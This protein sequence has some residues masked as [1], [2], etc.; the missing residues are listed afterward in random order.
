MDGS[1]AGN[2]LQ[3][4][5]RSRAALDL[6]HRLLSRD[7]PVDLGLDSVVG[8]LL[9][10]FVARSAGIADFQNGQS[11][12]VRCSNND[13]A[14]P[15]LFPWEIDAD[16]LSRIRQSP[17]AEVIVSGNDT[18]LVAG[19][20]SVMGG[21]WLIWI[22]AT[23]QS[24]CEKGDTLSEARG[25]SPLVRTGS[26]TGW[27]AAEKG[28]LVLVAQSIAHR[29]SDPGT[30]GRWVK[31]LEQR[32][33]QQ[34]LE[35]A[36]A[37]TRRL[38]HDFGNVLTG[39]L[40]F[41]ELALAHPQPVSGPLYRFLDEIYRSAQ[42]GANL[43][44]QLQ[45]FSRRQAVSHRNG[46]LATVLAEEETRFRSEAEGSIR[47]ESS[48][49]ADLPL[50]AFDLDPLREVLRA[51]FDNARDAV[52]EQG[53]VTVSAQCVLLSESDSLEHYGYLR[54]GPHVEVCV[55]DSGPGLSQEAKR[56][57][58]VEPFFT[59]KARRR[60]L[61]LAVA[62]GLLSAY[63]GGMSLSSKPGEG[64]VVKVLLPVAA[65]PALPV[66]VA[67]IVRLKPAADR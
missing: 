41:S 11:V 25:D 32:V 39:I 42:A 16:L 34:N 1:Q 67:A 57:L 45:L 19:V 56:R 9:A 14:P 6:A 49:A 46:S 53:T 63:H 54:P 36:A 7:E 23:P 60:G 28:A 48:I 65:K 52:A 35:Q 58:F 33:R 43:T 64:V 62:Y 10:A 55:R 12:I 18:F 3:T 5:D 30:S 51:V 61:G 59:S 21:G 47:W 15:S 2:G 29:I 8:E 44:H 24:L 22:G 31:Q 20:I 37:L 26:Q 40:G 38:A 4:P 13:G 17:D 27:T 50:V 66:S